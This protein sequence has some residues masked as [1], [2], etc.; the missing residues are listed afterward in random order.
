[1][2]REYVK[3][4]IGSTDVYSRK[5]LDRQLDRLDR[6]R[7]HDKER[8]KQLEKYIFELQAW[9]SNLQHIGAAVPEVHS[10]TK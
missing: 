7:V 10:K 2:T 8:I 4:V 1:M 9:K 3:R 5:Y 6:L